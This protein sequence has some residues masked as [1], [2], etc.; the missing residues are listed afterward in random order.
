MFKLDLLQQ[1]KFFRVVFWVDIVLATVTAACGAQG[2]ALLLAILAICACMASNQ[3]LVL[4]A[5]N[6]I[7]AKLGEACGK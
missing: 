3:K 1:Y 6:R 2:S 4:I 7:E 5:L